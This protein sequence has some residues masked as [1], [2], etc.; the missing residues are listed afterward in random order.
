MGAAAMPSTTGPK[1]S[2]LGRFRL[3]TVFIVPFVLQIVAIV[4]LVAYLAFS[5]GQKVVDDLTVRLRNEIG[6]RVQEK[7]LSFLEI[8]HSLNQNNAD[9][10]RLNLLKVK[11]TE[12]ARR[13]FQ[14]E[15]VNQK[16]LTLVGFGTEQPIYVDV[17]RL[18]STE[19][20]KLA[21]ANPDLANAKNWKI[22]LEGKILEPIPT[23]AAYDHRKRPWY[24]SA[25]AAG[26]P[27]WSG[28][29][30]T[31]TPQRLV[32]SA[33]QPVYDDK[34]ALFGV[35]VSALS[36]SGISDFL[37]TL[38]VGK[39]GQT[40][41]MERSGDLIATST[42]EKP[43]VVKE[44]QPK[45]LKA[46]ES[47]DALTRSTSQFLL[48]RFGDLNTIADTQRLDF[49]LDGA[50]QFVQVLPFRDD[51]GLSWLIVV[52]VPEADFMQE[53]D[54]TTR[55]TILLALFALVLGTGVGIVTTRWVTGPILKLNQAAGELTKGDWTRTV[56]IDRA[57]E[58]GDLAASFN[59]MAG[60]LK[61]TITTLEQRVDERT[62]E[63]NDANSSLEIRVAERTAD[64]AKAMDHLVQTEKMATLG[65]MVAG[66]THELNTPLS[67][68]RLAAEVLA[69]EVQTL[70]DGMLAGK[71]SRSGLD[72]FIRVSKE[73]TDL[74]DR[75]SE[76]S[77]ALIDSFKQVAVDQSSERRCR[78][79]LRK[80][81]DQTALTLGPTL[82]TKPFKLVIEIPPGLEL[83]SYPGP[84]EQIITNLVTN[85]LAHAFPE[86]SSG[87]MTISARRV[88]AGLEIIYCDDGV[89]VT[90][91][92]KL[93]IFDPFFTTK[94]G[95]GGSGL[96][97]Y[98]IYNLVTGLFRGTV[99]IDGRPG[100]GAK[101]TLFL[102]DVFVV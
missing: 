4:G 82:K 24:K 100:I 80:I 7:L 1:T 29:Y 89:G 13:Y 25:V 99:V 72:R 88:D 40:F 84:L 9:A 68:V 28:V 65:G 85:S 14:S 38:T 73:T 27:G 101:F 44:D 83:D 58:L 90:D 39:T 15:L 62:A 67:N 18:D 35:A 53:I 49:S 54:A 23:D 78:F 92:I 91:D 47:S 77:A 37:S 60:Q 36:L 20:L 56:K 98:T 3:R 31:K 75:A 81:V 34:R 86:R 48:Q 76:R 19:Y 97:M 8:P 5:T 16:A 51:K 6:L 33:T 87:L 74:I 45:R 94:A 102:P 52:V 93:R 11:D 30:V 32:V 66:I 61:E 46:V 57:D 22:D 70:A 79:D 12:V 64:L 95:Q 17:A 59:T 26:K 50:R 43:F 96:G 2:F 55:I 71:V 41:I 69:K 63:L 21:V 10:V 42:K